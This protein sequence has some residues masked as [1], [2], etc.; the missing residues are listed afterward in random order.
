MDLAPA[1]LEKRFSGGI[2]MNRTTLRTLIVATFALAAASCSGSTSSPGGGNGAGGGSHAGGACGTT[3]SGGAGGASSACVA[4][5]VLDQNAFGQKYKFADNE[6]SGWTQATAADDPAAFDVYTSV[7]DLVSR[8]DGEAD[9]YKGFRFAMFQDLM[10]PD[11]QTC[12]VVVMDFVTD[13]LATTEYTGQQGNG[14]YVIEVAGYDDSVAIVTTT[15]TG[16]NVYAHFKALYIELQ[17]SG[18]LAEDGSLDLNKAASAA[19]QFLAAL[20]TKT[21]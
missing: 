12:N 8:I 5:P 21:N 20:K 17:M 9:S 10:G 1:R 7:D 16:I 19:A 4:G 14:S 13:C 2:E 15:L 11:P 3:A 6:L 18:Y